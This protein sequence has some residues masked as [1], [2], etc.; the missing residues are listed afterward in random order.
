MEISLNLLLFLVNAC[1]HGE[2][3]RANLRQILSVRPDIDTDIDN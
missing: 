1:V 3:H 2:V